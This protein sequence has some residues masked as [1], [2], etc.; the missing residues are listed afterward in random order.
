MCSL[1]IWNLKQDI[2]TIIIIIIVITVTTNIFIV[3]RLV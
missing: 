1:V 3:D 2:I